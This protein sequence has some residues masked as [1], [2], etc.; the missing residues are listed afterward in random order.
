MIFAFLHDVMPHIF[1]RFFAPPSF[2]VVGCDCPEEYHGPVCEFHDAEDNGDYEKCSLKCEN[3]G[4]C[5]KGVKD[6]SFLD[7]FNLGPVAS[8]LNMTHNQ[9]F[10]HCVRPDGFTGHICD[11]QV[12]TCGENEHICLYGSK[13]VQD[14]DG[15]KCDCEGA[16]TTFDKFAG[17]NCQHKATEFCTANGELG[18]GKDNLSFCVNNGT[19]I[20]KKDGG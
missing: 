10:E 8:N 20:E 11:I 13:C 4:Q 14:G 12:E 15:H 17:N 7:K 1:A 18:V 2:S 5:R 3:D 19:C 16:F 6:T 9:D